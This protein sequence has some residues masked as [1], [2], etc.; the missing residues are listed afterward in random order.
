M[1]VRGRMT[2]AKGAAGGVRIDAELGNSSCGTHDGFLRPERPE[3]DEGA[4]ATPAPTPFGTALDPYDRRKPVGVDR[5][6]AGR[7]LS[8]T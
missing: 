1:K 6:G 5:V 8:R 4:V 7:R 2:L 3:F